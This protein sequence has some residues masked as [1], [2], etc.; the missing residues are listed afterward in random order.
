LRGTAADRTRIDDGTG[1]AALRQ[2]ACNRAADH[3][4]TNHDH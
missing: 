2:L 4:G 1:D 3:T